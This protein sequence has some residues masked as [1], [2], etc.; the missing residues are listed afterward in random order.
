MY[1]L[2]K[3]WKIIGNCSKIVNIYEAIYKRGFNKIVIMFS[4]C[5][6]F[7][8]CLC[9]PG[10]IFKFCIIKQPNMI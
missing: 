3:E 4:A 8:L 5:G 2:F 6:Y 10:F 7:C 9:C 1:K